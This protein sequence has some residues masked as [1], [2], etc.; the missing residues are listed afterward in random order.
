MEKIQEQNKFSV[1]LFSQFRTFFIIF[2]SFFST[3]DSVLIKDV[4]L[5]LLLS[6]MS[7]QWV[8]FNAVMFVILKTLTNLLSTVS[9]SLKHSIFHSISVS[10]Q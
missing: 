1:C 4:D 9:L 10:L 8:A 5:H 2:L 7:P 3:I 6:Q